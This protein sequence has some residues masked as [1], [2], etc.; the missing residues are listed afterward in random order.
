MTKTITLLS[1][2]FFSLL[3]SSQTIVAKYDFN[4]NADDGSGNLN[5]GIVHGATLTED[6]YGIPNNAYL[7][8]GN[9]YIDIP[10][11]DS[12]N[13]GEEDFAISMWIKTTSTSSTGM[14]IQKGSRGEYNSPQYWVR[15]PDSYL[16]RNI[17]FLTSNANPPSPYCYTD[18]IDIADGEWHHIVAQRSEKLLELYF[19]CHLVSSNQD[20]FR[21]I[22]DD[23]GVFIGA[24]HPHP[25]TNSIHNYFNG[26]IDDVIFFSDN[27]SLNEIQAY[28]NDE[29]QITNIVNTELMIAPN[30]F[31]DFI[32]INKNFEFVTV[33]NI[34]GEKVAS[35]NS[36]NKRINLSHLRKG[37]YIFKIETVSKT[38]YQKII[39]N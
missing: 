18:S 7:F 36:S 15:T 9:D 6:R 1:L 14:L 26:S 29:V 28:C 20:I 13:F 8:D 10:F 27:L 5:N 33:F 17:A 34:C 11:W 30:P 2:F 37:V 22:N 12:F 31:S 39:K 23:V 35:I 19:D 4:G 24:Q 16:D 25:G 32:T 38:I 3:L 21:D